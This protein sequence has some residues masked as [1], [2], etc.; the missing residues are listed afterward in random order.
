MLVD[1]DDYAPVLAEL[2]ASSGEA[3]AAT[4]RRLA[5]KVFHVTATY[6]GAIAD[7]LGARA[8]TPFGETFHWGGTKALD[9]RYGENPHQRAAL[10]GDF[11][12]VAA[13]L[14]GKELSYNNVVDVDAALAL[15]S[16]F[17]G[18]PETAQ[19]HAELRHHVGRRFE[20]LLIQQDR[21]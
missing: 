4:N 5:Q 15:A 3:S 19:R 7:Y 18:H 9:M 11:L 14:H 1:P 12:R 20:P 6:D 17:L 21:R 2:Q 13:P 10:Y 8:E 16:E